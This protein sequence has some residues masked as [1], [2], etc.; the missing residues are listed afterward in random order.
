MVRIFLS[1]NARDRK[2]CE[3][4]KAS[5]EEIGVIAYLAEHDA[6]PGANLAAKVADA[7]DASEAVVVL[8]SDN[9]V[10][11]PYVHQEIGYALKARKLII[12]L[13]QPGITSDK[14]AML[15]GVEYIPFDFDHPHD[16][17][18]Q[19]RTALQRLVRERAAKDQ[20]DAALLALACIALVLLAL[21]S[22]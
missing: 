6:R 11:A 21:D 18:V 4:L 13:V 8:I 15:Q 14:L 17:H 10:A 7:I 9:S 22:S 1:H 16:G 12:P 20:R 19:L 2:W 5:A 3:W